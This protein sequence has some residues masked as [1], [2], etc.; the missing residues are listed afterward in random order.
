MQSSGPSYFRSQ[1]R[2]AVSPTQPCTSFQKLRR[3]AEQTV[4]VKGGYNRWFE[5]PP[6]PD[7]IESASSAAPSS[8]ARG[9]G[10]AGRGTKRPAR[11]PRKLA[12]RG[13]GEVGADAQR[14]ERG[15][16]ER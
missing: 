15:E 3:K 12:R 6:S 10:V 4:A 16:E 2:N 13:G 11:M 14:K 8:R 7:S 5:A 1:N 9:R